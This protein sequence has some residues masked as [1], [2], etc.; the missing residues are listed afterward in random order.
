M[1]FKR[2]VPSDEEGEYPS[3]VRNEEE[4]EVE[5]VEEVLSS[6]VTAKLCVVCGETGAKCCGSC[7]SVTYCSK[8]CQTEHWPIHSDICKASAVHESPVV[9]CCV[10]CGSTEDVKR[11]SRCKSA[12]YCSQGC[13]KEHWSEHAGLCKTIHELEE[14]EKNKLYHNKSVRQDRANH[15]MKLKMMRLIGEKPKINCYLGGVKSRMLLDTG[16]GVTMVDRMWVDEYMPNVE[17]HPVTDFLDVPGQKLKLCAANSS[18]IQYDGVVLLNFGL[19]ENKDECIVPVLV[20][21]QKIVEPI[22]GHNVIKDLVK[23]GGDEVQGKLATCIESESGQPFDVARLV[24]LIEE[25]DKNGDFLA[26]VKTPGSLKVPAG[27]RKQVKCRVKATCDDEQTVYFSPKLSVDDED[28]EVLETVT[29]LRRGRTNF[30]YVDILNKSNEE[31]VVQKGSLLGSIH[32]VSAVVPMLSSR[33]RGERQ[34][35]VVGSVNVEE[36]SEGVDDSQEWVPPVDLSHLD[37]TQREKVIKVIIDNKYVFSKSD[38]DIG[39]IKDFHMKI[40]L[41]DEVPVKEAYRRIPRNLYTE[42]RDYI[43]DLLT[44]GWIRESHASYAS[45]IV[46]VRKKDGG[47]RMCVD[48]RKLNGKTVADAQ[49]IPRIQDILDGLAGKKWFSTLDMSKAYHQGY[50][51]EGSRHVTA[52]AT[53][54]TLYE[55]VRIPFGLRNA[56]PAFQ[57]Y[58]NTVLADM[59]TTICDPYLDDV[60][61]HAA[62]FDEGVVGLDKVLKRLKSKGI[63]LRAE[64]CCFLKQEVRY[65]GRLISGDGYRMDPADTE[66][67]EKFR[68]PPKNVGELRSM[69]GFVGYY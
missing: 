69:L 31:K 27:H 34:E 33:W 65:L 54:W 1:S 2:I 58:M 45:P 13:Q 35:E 6:S 32:S 47:L 51:K 26:E 50:I 29:K 8:K 3:D 68:E 23:E 67:L 24:S 64:K 15:Q 66:A 21:S 56:P 17:I 9:M 5:S 42:V 59:K 11:C 40:N 61:C 20:S 43:N 60:L 22:L 16:S 14:I 49:P 30:V 48:Y 37:E 28:I 12:K 52:F 38:V 39:D 41:H 57:R 46:C 55:W 7:N 62:E 25:D 10:M 19:D 44:N 18:E 53:P 4:E 36:S 63:K